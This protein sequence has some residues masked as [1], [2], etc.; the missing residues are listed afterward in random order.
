M[1]LQVMQINAA[2][3]ENLDRGSTPR[4]RRPSG[5]NSATSAPA[6]AV[7]QRSTDAE[8]HFKLT[9]SRNRMIKARLEGPTVATACIL[10]R[11]EK[12][13]RLSNTKAMRIWRPACCDL[14]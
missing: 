13:I 7:T 2:A 14:L 10:T 4:A 8:G 12:S 5:S 6:I 1:T 11:A 9:I 3:D